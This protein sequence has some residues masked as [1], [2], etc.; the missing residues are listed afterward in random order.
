M[1]RLPPGSEELD[2]H[3]T[4]LDPPAL[5]LE[6]EV[7]SGHR[8]APPEV[9]DAAVD[10]ER[11]LSTLARQLIG[12]PLSGGLDSLPGHLLLEVER[13]E[14]VGRQGLA[15]EVAA[16]GIAALGLVPHLAVRRVA[17]V[18]AGIVALLAGDPREPPLDVEDVVGEDLV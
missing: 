2:L 4:K 8:A 5:G 7:A 1:S 6:P 18:D 10:P 14:G 16:G 15:E 13:L 9:G 12:V 3:V 11:D 17:D